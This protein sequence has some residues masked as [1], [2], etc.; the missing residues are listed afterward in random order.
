MIDEAV[1]G[2]PSIITRHGR[3]EAVVIG[4]EDR[5]RPAEAL[6]FARL[7]MAASLEPGDLPERDGSPVREADL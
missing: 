2:K 5:C 1:H 4:F 6:S 3:H 7:L